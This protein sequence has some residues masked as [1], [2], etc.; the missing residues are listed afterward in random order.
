M[1]VDDPAGVHVNEVEDFMWHCVE[2][3]PWLDIVIVVVSDEDARGVH[4]KR[5]EPVEVDFLAHLQ[6]GGHQHQAAA[7]PLGPHTLHCPEPL[8]IEQVL[9]VEEEHA[10]LRVKVIQHVLDPERYICV[11]GV[12]ESGENHRGVLVVLENFIKRSPPFL[13]LLKSAKPER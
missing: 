12:V 8:H 11:A 3:R 5:P 10:P 13:Q 9:R 6:G 4:G 7:E 2:A 1:H